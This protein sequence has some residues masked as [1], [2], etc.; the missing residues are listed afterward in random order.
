MNGTNGRTAETIIDIA[1]NLETQNGEPIERELHRLALTQ[2][3]RPA[4]TV[5]A[6]GAKGA[7]DR[8]E[9]KRHGRQR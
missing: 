3:M 9:P 2:A 5:Q 6:I 1:D 4:G 7:Q 8:S